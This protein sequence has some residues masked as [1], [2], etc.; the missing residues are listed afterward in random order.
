MS[1]IGFS[2][3]QMNNNPV[4][5]GSVVSTAGTIPVTI[6]P[7]T[8]GTVGPI[9][10][11]G[12]YFIIS[13]VGSANLYV[14]PDL[15]DPTAGAPFNL[16]RGVLVAPGESFESACARG[17]NLSLVGSTAGLLQEF[18]LTQFN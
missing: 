9:Q 7:A 11:S 13:N 3:S 17:A 10:L 2:E 15:A 16:G 8:Q 5:D 4:W 12:T 1:K 18:S 6:A 14:V